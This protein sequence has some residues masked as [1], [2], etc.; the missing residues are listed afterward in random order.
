VR[1]ALFRAFALLAF[2][3]STVSLAPG[4]GAQRT[5]N[6]STA[7]AT[8]PP[9][10]PGVCTPGRVALVLAGG[11]AKG[12]A[13]VGVI[14]HLDSLGIYPDLVVGTSI[15][16]L[17]GAMYASGWDAEA[18]ESF[19]FRFNVGRYI[20]G[21]APS[22]PR[23][24]G[25]V[26]PLLTWNEGA[27]GGFDFST[28][29]VRE[30]NVNLIASAMLLAGNLRAAGDFDRLPTPFRAVAADLRTGDPI[31]LRSGDLAEAVR[32]SFAIPLVFQPLVIDG[33]VLVDGGV[34]ENAPVAVART[35]GATRVILSEMADTLA[36]AVERGTTGTVASSLMRFLFSRNRP[37]MRPGDLRITSNTT[38]TSSLDFSDATMK[39]M[40]ERGREAARRA[41]PSAECLPTKRRVVPDLPPFAARRFTSQTTNAEQRLSHIIFGDI[42]PNE[43]SLDT[44]MTRIVRVSEGERLN[45]LWISPERV[46]V[47][48]PSSEAVTGTDSVLIHPR[49]VFAPRRSLVAGLIYDGE[50]GGRAWLGGVDRNLIGWPLEFAARGALGRYRQDVLVGLR[51]ND[52]YIEL[53]RSP[54]LEA[55]IARERVRLFLPEDRRIEIPDALLPAFSDQKLR[56]GMEQPLGRRWTLQAA[57]LARRV[58]TLE[59]ETDST[60]FEF[61]DRALHVLGGTVSFVRVRS[62]PRFVPRVDL[63]YTNKYTRLQAVTA[64]TFTKGLFDIAMSSRIVWA[65]RELPLMDATTLGGEEGF[66]GLRIF[67]QRGM[68]EL[69]TAFE[70]S[71]PVLGPLALQLTV[72][73]GQVS[74]DQ[75]R[76][77]SGEWIAGTRLGLGAAT[78]IGPLRVQYGVN[79]RQDHRWFVRIGRWF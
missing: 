42:S 2:A 25:P 74:E 15:G 68:A 3:V 53:T 47:S 71:R 18:L 46:T 31:V 65:D 23:A 43:V 20:G 34:A 48:R 56:I 78:P 67:E 11:G 77:L 70:I 62:D 73:G 13:H 58:T 63:E 41:I 64:S 60:V 17:V 1:H 27:G 8:R 12:M 69:S 5:T 32:A 19:V 54:F 44:V 10:A 35:E 50:L 51:R 22:A 26:L 75:Y 39:L 7:G 33:R 49:L 61:A 30:G 16:A 38:G 24:L 79:S 76:P 59:D 29:A 52:Q 45:A 55:T 36:T 57:G 4:L 14:Q 72:Q 37:E 28:S 40:I 21:Y 9:D 6:D 66:A